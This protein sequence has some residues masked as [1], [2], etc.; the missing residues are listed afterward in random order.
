L[1]STGGICIFKYI[2]IVVVVVVVVVRKRRGARRRAGSGVR[3]VSVRWWYKQVLSGL[4][5]VVY[6]CNFQGA[7]YR[8]WWIKDTSRFIELSAITVKVVGLIVRF[9]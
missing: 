8:T 6:K 9:L 1:E 4:F 5:G 3:R 2:A 7:R